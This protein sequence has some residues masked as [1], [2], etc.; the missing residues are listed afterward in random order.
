MNAKM[1]TDM[2]LVTAFREFGLKM[3]KT[4]KIARVAV[5]TE[6][7]SRPFFK[8][9]CNEMGVSHTDFIQK[10]KMFIAQSK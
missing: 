2:E 8:Q 3:D 10:S 4:T 9:K 6:L 1:M 5:L 7:M